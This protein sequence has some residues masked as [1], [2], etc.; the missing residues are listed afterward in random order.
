MS[1]VYFPASFVFVAKR[2]LR[3]FSSL[4]V[5]NQYLAL[6]VIEDPEKAGSDTSRVTALPASVEDG[7]CNASIAVPGILE[8][9]SRWMPYFS[10]QNATGD[11]GPT[12]SNE[13]EK[14]SHPFFPPEPPQDDTI[15][16]LINN[17]VLFDPLHAPRYP[18]VLCH[19]LYGFD[20]RG[21]GFL[22]GLKMRYW[23]NLMPILRDKVGAEVIVTTVPP[24]GSISSRA[25]AL[26]RQLKDKMRGRG[27]NFLAHSMGGLDCRHLITHLKPS[28]YAPLS[29]TSISTPH[30]GSP[31]MDWCA[32]HIGLGRLRQEEAR[33][34]QALREAGVTEEP[35]PNPLSSPLA[36]FPS[37][38]TAL[39]LSVVD[40][41]AYA[42]LTTSY[43]N[44]V[45][46][47]CTPD[48][49]RVKYFSVA[50]RVTNIPPW[51]FFWFPHMIVDGAEQKQREDLRR[52]WEK[53][54]SCEEKHV[55]ADQAPEW[56]RP[57]WARDSEWGNDGLV[58]V[59]SAK[60][61]EYLGVMEECD[62]WEMRGSRGIEFGVDLPPIP[63]INMKKRD[64]S[65][66]GEPG[67]PEGWDVKETSRFIGASP[68]GGFA[69]RA[70]EEGLS[71]TS[72]SSTP[73]EAVSP[74]QTSSA[75]RKEERKR[76]RERDDAAVK[77]STEKLSAVFDW[78]VDLVPTP[79][80]DSLKEGQ[81]K[82][83]QESQRRKSELETQQ[84]LERFY[85]SLTRKLYDEG[86]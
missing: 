68:E 45:F 40:T 57:L 2:L 27:V 25:E 20:T 63:S 69:D 64:P 55:W 77:A 24:T 26:N 70:L 74:A 79:T 50:G 83:V 16:R 18:I 35:A 30:R 85:T 48:D 9:L 39:L 11:E 67:K 47:P 3:V 52:A 19:G 75:E 82:K 60:W 22:P 72:Y 78:I 7:L 51:S 54:H 42:N 23:R 14:Q 61:G 62:H 84:D 33:L 15:H 73:D 76:D 8:K 29:L 17:P 56:L 46:N 21:P 28:E 41:P 4:A 58:T 36:S 32:E 71:S 31:F 81:A 5:S 1:S 12:P 65:V 6:R 49:P 43:L 38:F 80:K 13:P 44:Q 53:N 66:A 10:T 86:L 59:Q 37:S 34:A